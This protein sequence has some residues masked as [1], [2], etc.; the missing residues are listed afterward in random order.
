MNLTYTKPCKR[1]NTHNLVH[2]IPSQSNVCGTVAMSGHL[3][4]Q[5]QKE[6]HCKFSELIWWCFIGDTY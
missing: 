5:Q 2:V 3:F 6:I 4:L 1:E